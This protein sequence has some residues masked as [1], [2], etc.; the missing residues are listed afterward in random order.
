L[1]FGLL[2]TDHSDSSGCTTASNLRCGSPC[3]W[4][5]QML[6]QFVCRW[7]NSGQSTA[8]QLARFQGVPRTQHAERA[9]RS[10]LGTGP[11]L[12]SSAKNC[13]SS[14]TKFSRLVAQNHRVASPTNQTYP[15]VFLP[16]ESLEVS[17]LFAVSRSFDDFPITPSFWNG[18]RDPREVLSQ[19]RLNSQ[20]SEQNDLPGPIFF[21]KRRI[22]LKK[23]QRERAP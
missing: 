1:C 2:C 4:P 22:A 5:Q 14:A 16:E 15:G 13:G 10:H 7:T 12:A 19:W 3:Y 9:C 17:G 11:Q 21:T 8:A 20:K 6:L 18:Q 23:A